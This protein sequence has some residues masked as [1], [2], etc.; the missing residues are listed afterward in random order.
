[1]QVLIA[2]IHYTNLKF[3]QNFNLPK[4]SQLNRECISLF[5]L[6]YHASMATFG[7]NLRVAVKY[8][9]ITV[10]FNLIEHILVASHCND[11]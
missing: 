4:Y 5:I 11:T 10:T 7:H 8:S 6:L 3:W 1:M 2:Y 9:N